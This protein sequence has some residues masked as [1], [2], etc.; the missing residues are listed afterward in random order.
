MVVD[1]RMGEWVYQ[2]G[3]ELFVRQSALPEIPG[4]NG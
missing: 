3:S 4:H 2:N 1:G